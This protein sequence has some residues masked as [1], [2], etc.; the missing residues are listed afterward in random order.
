M[1][2]VTLYKHEF[3]DDS[4]FNNS[5]SHIGHILHLILI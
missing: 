5:L 3:G 4:V 2:I 1:T